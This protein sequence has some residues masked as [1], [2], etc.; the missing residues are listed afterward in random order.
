MREIRYA[1]EGMDMKKLGLCFIRRSWLVLVAAVLG[2]MLGAAVY[3]SA[4]V[5]PE[6]ERQYRAMSKVYLDFEV[7][8]TG[9]VYQQYNGYTWNDLMATD[10]ILNVTMAYL[11]ADYTREEVM[12]ATKAE[13]L[14]DVRLLTITI[15]THDRDRCN[16]ILQA[17][18]RSL[19]ERG[20]T[21]KE[22]KQISVIQT[23]KA[24]PVIAD[25]RMKQAVLVGIVGAVVLTLLGMMFYYVLDDRIF[26]A[27]DL[28]QV[29]DVSFIGYAGAGTRLAEEYKENLMYLRRKAGKICVVAIGGLSEQERLDIQGASEQEKEDVHGASS[30]KR[31]GVQDVMGQERS[32]MQSA[33][34]QE[35]AG[36]QNASQQETKSAS[37][38]QFIEWEKGISEE[39]WEEL[40]DADRVVLAIRYGRVH[41]TYLSYI[42]EQLQ[43]RECRL[44]G[45]AISGAD[46][47]FLRRYYG[48]A[49][50][51][52]NEISSTGL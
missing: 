42:L 40:C 52:N 8:E 2:A 16:E 3:A 48:S 23:T 28:K 44:A 18:G 30:Q 4:S 46:V 47:K 15:T 5:V 21:A 37:R 29:T 50:G 39:Q 51:R 24:E 1:D 41:A 26:V 43:S 9:E 17:T 19:T 45:V 25:S 13:I 7:D 36:V 14:S 33:S 35:S 11:P 10:P 34:R 31:V 22:F 32:D 12:A 27:N 38:G 49:F 20:D 6:S